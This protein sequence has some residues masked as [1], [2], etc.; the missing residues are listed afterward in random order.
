MTELLDKAI[1]KVKTLSKEAQ[2]AIATMILEELEDETKWD[3]SFANSQDILAKVA[4][5]A[6]AEYHAGE[7]EELNPDTL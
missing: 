5:E 7:T 6:L 1:A 2:D 4:T 3:S